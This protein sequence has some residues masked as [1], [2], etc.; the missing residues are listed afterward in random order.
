MFRIAPIVYP[1]IR[2]GGP[3]GAAVI[4]IDQSRERFATL[5]SKATGNALG[6]LVIRIDCPTCASGVETA[7]RRSS[8]N[9]GCCQAR[10]QAKVPQD[11]GPLAGNGSNLQPPD[12]KTRQGGSLESQPVSRHPEFPVIARSSGANRSGEGD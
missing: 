9:D 3:G 4:A 6:A 5:P 2:R 12:P 11:A 10:G 1:S 8:C 7:G